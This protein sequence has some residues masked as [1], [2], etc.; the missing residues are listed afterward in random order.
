MERYIRTFSSIIGLF[1]Q[2]RLTYGIVLGATPC[3]ELYNN[4]TAHT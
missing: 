4:P 1:R 3:L 2:L